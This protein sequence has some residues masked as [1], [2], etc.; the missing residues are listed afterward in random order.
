MMKLFKE[1]QSRPNFKSTFVSIGLVTIVI[2]LLR[3]PA[4]AEPLTLPAEQRPDWLSRDGIVM[5]GSWEP[6]LFR[7]R[8]D[9]SDGYTPSAEQRAAYERKHSPEMIAE[10][11]ALGVNFI[12][13]H[14]YKVAGD[15]NSPGNRLHS[16]L[17]FPP[18]R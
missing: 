14:C 8:R 6:L 11:K 12:M 16:Q 3:C 7:V 2:F 18:H 1:I 9:G 15:A 5:A 10:L 13:M 17:D 4:Q